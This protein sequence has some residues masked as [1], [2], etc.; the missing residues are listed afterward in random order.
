MIQIYH[1][2]AIINKYKQTYYNHKSC[3]LLVPLVFN[4]VSSVC[5]L[6]IKPT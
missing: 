4:W 1:L 6:I 5:P 2:I 3:V